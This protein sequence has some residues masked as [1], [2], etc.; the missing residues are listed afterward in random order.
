[1]IVLPAFADGPDAVITA[2]LQGRRDTLGDTFVAGRATG[3]GSWT[4]DAVRLEGY[5]ELGWPAGVDQPLVPE[6]FVLAADGR[7]GQVD[8]TLGRQRLDLP[9][10]G[11]MLDGGRVGWTP[12]AGARLEAW[13]GQARHV[14]LDGLT[15]GAPVGRFAA[16]LSRGGASAT[17][18][19]WAEGGEDPAIHPDLRLRWRGAGRLAPDVAAVG[20]LA[21]ADRTIVERARIE[22]GL[23]PMGG[24]RATLHA[25]H[26]EALESE[27]GP[28]ILAALAPDGTN[29]LG[30]GF[31]WTST[32]R[33]KLWIEGGV[34]VWPAPGGDDLGLVGTVSWR[35]TCA[36][37][38]WCLY[39]TFRGASGPGGL[40][41][42]VGATLKV[43]T[44]DVVRL[45]FDGMVVPYRKPHRAWDTAA[46]LRTTLEIHPEDS[47]ITA[48]LGGEIAHD[49]IADVAP[50]AW[51]LLRMEAL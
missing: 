25:E 11:R 46:S 12:A 10:Y 3:W 23:R 29:E 28:S 40:Y 50:R 37:G 32:R 30:A 15:S 39:P 5:G 38:T 41:D 47:A 26:R 42:A 49:A 1:M 45:G 19:A 22:A 51:V 24:V 8:W 7:T 21:V 35:P 36:T 9:V 2:S 4:F 16:T 33:S 13:A 14:G 31:G 17:A 44:P 48:L 20:A 6:L 18:A 27:L 43:P 34:Q